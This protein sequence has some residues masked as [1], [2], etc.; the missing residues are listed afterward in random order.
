[1]TSPHPSSSAPPLSTSV[2][3]LRVFFGHHK[4]ATG[5][6]GALLREVALH[7]GR[8]F[9]VINRRCDFSDFTSLGHYVDERRV[10][11][12]SYAN[13]D[14]QQAR[15]LPPHIGFHVVRDPRD[16]LVSAYFSHKNTHSTHEGWPELEAH[17]QRLRSTSKEAGLFAEMSFSAPFFDDMMAWDYNQSTVLELKMETVTAAPVA[18]F[19]QIADFLGILQDDSNGRV[20]HLIH[21]LMS[22]SNRLNHRGRRF[23]P[24]NVPIFPSPKHA[25]SDLTRKIV[26][27]IVETRSFERLTG[28]RKGQENRGSH[29]RKGVP[30]DWVNHFTPAHIETFKARYNELILKLGYE[31]HPDW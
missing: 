29:L 22:K 17:R 8:R 3:P 26:V 24:G 18:S 12:L 30:G 19:V 15:T 9:D 5:W 10:E 14:I 7:M 31:D 28:R 13:A 21:R 2:F 16:V 20:R 4:C 23:M 27:E 25:L 1:M 11:M 6:I